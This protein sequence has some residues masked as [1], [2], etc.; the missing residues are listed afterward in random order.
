MANNML[1]AT[2][3]VFLAYDQK[4][5]KSAPKMSSASGKKTFFFTYLNFGIHHFSDKRLIG[6]YTF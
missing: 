6:W 3:P 2:L 5:E 4:K 1:D